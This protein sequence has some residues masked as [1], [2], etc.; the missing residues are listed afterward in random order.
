M[1]NYYRPYFLCYG[2]IHILAGLAFWIAPALTQIFLYT[3]LAADAAALM[4]FASALAG[5]GFIG[6]A[7]VT[8]PRQ[9]K[10]V[11]LLSVGGNLLN[12]AVHVQNV[13]R[14]YSP[15]SLLWVAVPSIVVM[16]ALL[17]LTR[18]GIEDI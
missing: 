18:R 13:M 16:I 8:V 4:G 3:P 12:L 14:G 5:L 6:A 7:F 9:Q 15:P 1:A 17:V 10:A 11:L 2:G